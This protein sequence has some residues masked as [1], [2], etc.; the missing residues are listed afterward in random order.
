LD[1]YKLSCVVSG[2][3][4]AAQRDLAGRFALGAANLQLKTHQ[5]FTT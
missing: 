2:I 4:N 5:A 1:N 3:A